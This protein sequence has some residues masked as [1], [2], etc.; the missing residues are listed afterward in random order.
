MSVQQ[1]IEVLSEHRHRLTPD[2]LRSL[3]DIWAC[4]S[5]ALYG[6]PYETWFTDDPEF[7]ATHD[8]A[9]CEQPCE[10]LPCDPEWIAVYRLAEPEQET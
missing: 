10:P 5:A 4:A 2:A 7:Y 8:T 1:A 3:Q 6:E 9:E